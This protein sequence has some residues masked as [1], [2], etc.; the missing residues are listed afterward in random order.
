MKTYS[1]V[2]IIYNPNAKKGKIEELIP[3]IK[4]RLSLRYPIVEAMAGLTEFAAEELS[5]SYADKYDIVVS[6]G[7]DGTLHQVINGVAKSKANPLIGVLPYGTCNDV[8]HTLNIPQNLDK[9]I[10]CILRLNTCK[11]DIM[12]DGKNYITYS[13]AAGYFTPVSFSASGKLKKSFGRFAYFLSALKYCSAKYLPCTITY[14]DQHYNGPVAFIM[15]INGRSVAGFKLNKNE[16]ISNGKA[17]LVIVKGL[18]KIPTFF[19]FLKIFLF[20]IKSVKNNKKI[21]VDDVDSIEIKNHA[22][23]PFAVD[24]EKELFLKKN[25]TVTSPITFIT[26]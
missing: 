16:D 6:C 17:K 19:R 12:F 15:L 9:A 4:K 7:G 3:Y 11:Y 5:M 1:S 25:I 20:G 26:K 21:I 23:V 8:S 14:K 22:N 18:K 2:L 13:L 24:G 10:D